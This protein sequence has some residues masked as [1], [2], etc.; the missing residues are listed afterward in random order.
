MDCYDCETMGV[1]FKTYFL[2][3]HYYYNYVINE[4][5]KEEAI[6]YL[7][8]VSWKKILKLK[9]KNNFLLFWF[10]CSKQQKSENHY[11]IHKLKTRHS[12]FFFRFLNLTK[13]KTVFKNT[14]QI[15]SNFKKKM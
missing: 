8:F 1:S 5:T 15:N 12:I 13:D 10:L 4:K 9:N 3:H 7:F 11:E 2:N 6:L 14:N